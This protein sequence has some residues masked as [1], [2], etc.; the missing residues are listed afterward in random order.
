MTTIRNVLIVALVSGLLVTSGCL[1]ILSGDE[2]FEASAATTDEET[3]SDH[4]YEFQGTERQEITRQFSAAGE[5]KNVTAVNY[6]STY[7]RTLPVGATEAKAGVFAVISTPQ[8]DVLGKTFNPVG[9][10][11]NE[12]LVGLVQDNYESLSVDNDSE[13]VREGELLGETTDVSR[14]EGNARISGQDVDVYVHVTKVKHDG[15]FVVAVAIYPQDLPDVLGDQ[16]EAVFEM[17]EAV[18]HDEE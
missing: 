9:E 5:T 15:D 8:V 14:F 1:G 17:L 18:E 13:T 10:M 11:E 4:D 7:E 16:E 12:E 3:A 2:T 6:V